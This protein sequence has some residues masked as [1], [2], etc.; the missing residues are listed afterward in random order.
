MLNHILRQ[1]DRVRM[2]LDPE[3][4]SYLPKAVPNGTLGTITGRARA[5]GIIES[6][7]PVSS[8]RSPG[9]YS[10]DGATLVLWDEYPDGVDPRDPDYARVNTISL[11][12]ADSFVKEYKARYAE[13]WPVKLPNGEFN[14]DFCIITRGYELDN[15]MRTGDLPETA[16]WELDMVEHEG[17][18]YRINRINY[19]G[20]GP[21]KAHCYDM[22][23]IDEHGMYARHGSRTVEPEQL[24]LVSRGN[25]WREA[26]G[27]PLVFRS[28]GEEASFASGMNRTTSVRNPANGL[29]KW[30]LEEV[31]QAIRD[32]LV[33]GFTNGSMMFS[34]NK[35]ISATRFNDRNL[36]ERIRA[37]TLKGFLQEA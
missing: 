5:T 13:L 29:Y 24:T 12:P 35:R 26:H 31:L 32:D 1:G 15:L 7:Y 8:F 34:D 6:R 36:G 30:T 3:T 9:V 11:E 37:E 27:E 21:E 22:E 14:P 25:V 28:L 33:D 17:K 23:E 10:I 4:R 18:Q 19:N 16:F 2:K 20:W